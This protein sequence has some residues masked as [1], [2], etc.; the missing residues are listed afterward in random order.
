MAPEVPE[1]L[2]LAVGTFTA[3]R[4]RPPASVDR[5]TVRV[6]LAW[7]P[8]VAAVLGAVAS[9]TLEAV[10]RVTDSSDAGVALGSVLAVA[11]VAVLSRGLHLD[12]LADTAD[13]LGS[14]RPAAAAL[15]VM[16]RPDIGP[17]GVA[18]LVLVL[19]V[20][21]AAVAESTYRG[22]GWL[23]VLV[24]V[25]AGRAAVWWGCVRGVPA[26]R[27]DGLG[28]AF[29][30]SLPVGAA[31][32]GTVAL[33]V[34]AAA[35]AWLDDD[36]AWSVSVRAAGAVALAAVAAVLLVRWCRARLGGITGDVLG[37]A[38]EVGT[39]AA[40]LSFALL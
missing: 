19:L 33:A 38:V 21:V 15:E 14:R 23:G 2:R 25:A 22:T 37:A 28:A 24:S 1:G 34:A 35:L 17:F 29:A 39:T 27:S 10:R 32:L 31:L 30:G 18:T 26:A 3:V 6:A 36:R 16:R 11:S 9:T 40:L 7:A 20:Q 13:G 4:V 5:H 8:A 12:G